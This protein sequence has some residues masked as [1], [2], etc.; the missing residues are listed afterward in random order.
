VA[1]WEGRGQLT[2]KDEADR[3][4]ACW[5]MG[6]DTAIVAFHI[7]GIRL[8]NFREDAQNTLTN[9]PPGTKVHSA[10]L[11][12]TCSVDAEGDAGVHGQIVIVSDTAV[13]HFELSLL[14]V[15]HVQ[16]LQQFS[17]MSG[18]VALS[19]ASMWSISP[20]LITPSPAGLI[21]VDLKYHRYLSMSSTIQARISQNIQPNGSLCSLN[22]FMND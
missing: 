4:V 19:T 8:W 11:L 6:R 10:H 9:W 3:V 15:A 2:S 12:P 21:A 5:P 7:Q 14:P 13:L 17:L 22:H 1:G 16:P 20:I 18:M